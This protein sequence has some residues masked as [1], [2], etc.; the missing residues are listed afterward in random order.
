VSDLLSI[1]EAQLT[2]D[3][4][5]ALK[6]SLLH[7]SSVTVDLA[8]SRMFLAANY[9]TPFRATVQ[10]TDAKEAVPAVKARNCVHIPHSDNAECGLRAGSKFQS[11][12]DAEPFADIQSSFRDRNAS[13]VA[14]PAPPIITTMARPIAR[15]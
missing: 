4:E 12:P 11:N 3:G 15:I 9:R 10:S 8:S 5:T 7:A 2:L 1:N 6:I 13:I 14:L